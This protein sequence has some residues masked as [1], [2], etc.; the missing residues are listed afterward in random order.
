MTKRFTS[1]AR[2]SVN[3]IRLF[4]GFALL[5]S[6]LVLPVGVAEAAETVE[7]EAPGKMFPESRNVRTPLTHPNGNSLHSKIKT[8]GVACKT[9]DGVAALYQV[10]DDKIETY[11]PKTGTYTNSKPIN[12]VDDN[13]NGLLVDPHG[14]VFAAH[15]VKDT[16]PKDNTKFNHEFVQ[17]F[18]EDGTFTV[19]IEELPLEKK[20]WNAGTYVE[21]G[22]VPYA[23]ISN[24]FANNTPQLINLNTLKFD[25]AKFGVSQKNV[26][27]YVWVEEGIKVGTNKNDPTYHLVGIWVKNKSLKVYLSD[28]NGNGETVSSILDS[29]DFDGTYGAAYNFKNGSGD[30]ITTS[31][32]FSNNDKGEMT[33]LLFDAETKKFTLKAVGGSED[34]KNNDGGGCPFTEAGEEWGSVNVLNVD[35]DIQTDAKG[36]EYVGDETYFQIEITNNS[37]KSEEFEIYATV[38][39]DPDDGNDPVETT[40]KDSAKW[41]WKKVPVSA[42]SK[43]TFYGKVNWGENWAVK[44][45]DADTKVE[46][47]FTPNGSDKYLVLD[48]DACKGRKPKE[49]NFEPDATSFT[50]ACSEETPKIPQVTV[51]L[52]NSDSTVDATFTFVVEGGTDPEPIRVEAEEDYTITIN[53]DQDTEW[54]I[55]WTAKPPED[56]GLNSVEGK[57]EP[58]TKN[59]PTDCKDD[60]KFDPTF[61]VEIVCNDEKIPEL[62]FVF[63]NSKS[64]VGG[65]LEVWLY[66]DEAPFDGEG[67]NWPAV[68]YFSAGDEDPW[69]PVPLP[70]DSTWYFDWKLTPPEDSVFDP[71]ESTE[72]QGVKS[73]YHFETNLSD[74]NCV[75]I[76]ECLQLC[77]DVYGYV[78]VDSNKDGERTEIDGGDEDHVKGVEVVLSNVSAILNADG[79][80]NIPKGEYKREAVTGVDP[81]SGTDESNYRWYIADVHVEDFSGT[82]NKIEWQVTFDY[83]NAEWPEGFE[84]AGY[85]EKI[86]DEPEGKVISSEMDSDV[87]PQGGSIGVSGSFF[88]NVDEE[89]HRA[90]A[91]VI[92]GDPKVFEPEITVTLQCT[93]NGFNNPSVDLTIIVDNSKSEVEAIV[94]V[95]DGDNL[96]V[97]NP[98]DVPAGDDRA[99]LLTSI[100]EHGEVFEVRVVAAENEGLYEPI[101]ESVTIDCPRFDVEVEL[102]EIDCKTK[103]ATVIFKNNSDVSVS[104]DYT[105]SMTMI[106]GGKTKPPQKDSGS[107]PSL[108]PGEQEA[109]QIAVD[110]NWTW[111]L[112][113]TVEDDDIFSDHEWSDRGKLETVPAT[114]FVPCPG[115]SEFE[116]EV[117]ISVECT[118]EGPE[119]TYKVDNRSSDVDVE[120]ALWNSD[121]EGPDYT[122][123]VKAGEFPGTVSFP[124][125]A[126]DLIWYL[127]VR[128]AGGIL[129]G[130]PAVLVEV[131]VECHVP[132]LYL[133]QNCATMELEIVVNNSKPNYPTTLT[134]IET[135]PG[136]SSEEVLEIEIAANREFRRY[137]SLPVSDVEGVIYSAT[138]TGGVGSSYEPVTDEMAITCEWPID[139]KPF[140]CANNPSLLQLIRV[141]EEEGFVVKSLDLSDGTY[142]RLYEMPYDLTDPKF[143]NFNAVAIDPT[144]D[145]AYGVVSHELDSGR[146][147]FL[148]RFGMSN[149]DSEQKIAY[150]AEILGNSNSATIDDDGDFLFL[151]SGSLYLVDKV[152]DLKGF[153]SYDN[154]GVLDLTADQPIY[155]GPFE[156]HATDI[157]YA[158]FINGASVTKS[159]FG[160]TTSGHKV[161]RINYE[162]GTTEGTLLNPVDQNGVAVTFPPGGFG[163]AWNT[164]GRIIL[165]FN[166]GG[167][168]EIYPETITGSQVQVRKIFDT[169]GTGWNDGMNCANIPVC[170]PEE[171]GNVYG[172]A[173]ADWEK[174]GDRTPGEEHLKGVTVTLTLE[175]EYKNS[176]GDV[177]EDYGDSSWVVQTDGESTTDYE[178]R[179]NDV[180][181][182]DNDGNDLKYKTTFDYSTVLSF[183]TG[184]SPYGYTKRLEDEVTDSEIDSDVTEI[185]I[186]TSTQNVDQSLLRIKETD[187]MIFRLLMQHKKTKQKNISR[188]FGMATPLSED[189]EPQVTTAVSDLFTLE[190]NQTVHRADAGIV[191][192]FYFE[193]VVE[194]TIDCAEESAI[195]SLDNSGSSVSTTF[196]VDVYHGSEGS[197]N[198]VVDQSGEQLVAAGDT[199]QYEKA[200]PP[201]LGVLKVKVTAYAEHNGILLGPELVASNDSGTYCDPPFSVTLDALVKCP[202]LEIKI[203]NYSAEQLNLDPLPAA[204]PARIEVTLYVDGIPQR[205]GNIFSE[206]DQYYELD[207]GFLIFEEIPLEEGSVW[208]LEYKITDLTYPE[209]TIEGT[210]IGPEPFDCI[211]E[212]PPDPEVTF[213][214]DCATGR[215]VFTIDNSKSLWNIDFTI[216]KLGEIIRGPETVNAKV[217]KEI[218]LF[219][220]HD[221]DYIVLLTLSEVQPD[222]ATFSQVTV[223]EATQ[224]ASQIT[225]QT[226]NAGSQD[227][228]SVVEVVIESGDTLS[229][230]AAEHGIKTSELMAANGIEDASRIYIGQKLT[231][232]K[233]QQEPDWEAI[234]QLVETLE[235]DKNSV[236][237]AEG[238][239]TTVEVE[240]AGEGFPFK[241]DCPVFEPEIDFNEFCAD[242][243]LHILV[244]NE[245]SDIAGE[246]LIYENGELVSEGAVLPG[247]EFK[248]EY[249]FTYGA[250]YKVVV[251]PVGSSNGFSYDPVDGEHEIGCE[252]P[253][254]PSLEASFECADY[255]PLATVKLNNKDSDS[256]TEFMLTLVIDGNP[257]RIEIGPINVNAGSEE[258]ID[259]TDEF[260]VPRSAL[261][262]GTWRFEWTATDTE[263]ENREKTGSTPGGNRNDGSSGGS[264]CIDP[265]GPF[266]CA[267]YLAPLQIVLADSGIGY[268]LNTLNLAT[269]FLEDIYTIPFN[270]TIPSYSEIN[271][272]GLNPDPSDQTIYGF[273]RIKEDNVSSSY[274]IRFD[275]QQ[276]EY[277]AQVTNFPNAATF[278]DQGNFL[279]MTEGSLYKAENAKDIKGYVDHKD[280]RVPDLR[281]DPPVYDARDEGDVYAHAVDIAHV[282]TD[283]GLGETDY[284]VGMV[285]GADQVVLIGYDGADLD[286]RLLDS[287][288]S[289]G[290]TDEL[291]GG[292]YGSAWSIGGQVFVAA[293]SGEVFQIALDGTEVNPFPFNGSVEIR[294]VG[295]SAVSAHNDGTNCPGVPICFPEIFGDAYGYVWIDWD[296]SKDRTDIEYGREEHIAGVN[297]ILENTSPFYDSEGE[298][299]YQPGELKV[300]STITGQGSSAGNESGNYRWWIDDLPA[301]DNSG[302]RIKYEAIFDYAGGQ[303]PQGFTPTGYTGKQRDDVLSSEK[304]SD[305][306]PQ[307]FTRSLNTQAVSGEFTIEPETST[308]TADAGVIGEPKF[309]PTATV[310]IDCDADTADIS[311]DNSESTVQAKYEI[312]VYHGDVD[313]NNLVQ[314]Q[315]GDKIVEAYKTVEYGKY[316]PP[317]RGQ[318]LTILITATPQKEDLDLGFEPVTVWNQAG[319]DCPTGFVVQVQVETDCDSGGIKVTLDNSES[320]VDARF[321]LVLGTDTET[322]IESK[323][324]TQ[325]E[326]EEVIISVTE[327]SEWTLIWKAVETGESEEEKGFVG[328]IGPEQF[329]CEPEEFLPIVSVDHVC[330]ILGNTATFSIDNTGSGVNAIVEVYSDDELIWGPTTIEKGT[331]SYETT[332]PVTGIEAITIRVAAEE[333][334]HNYGTTTIKET[335]NCPETQ[336]APFD[337]AAFPALIQIVGTKGVGFEVKELNPAS[338]EYRPIYS[339]PFNRTPAFSGMNGAGINKVDSTAYALM[340]LNPTSPYLVRFDAQEVLFVAK[341]PEFSAAGDV[342]EDGN[343]VWPKNTKRTLSVLP[344]IA[345]LEGFTNPDDAADMSGLSPTLEGVD[346]PVSDIATMIYDFGDG[347]G[348]YAMGLLGNDLYVYRYDDPNDY[349][350][351]KVMLPEG[352]TSPAPKGDF[353][354]AWSHED[355]I[356][357]ASNSGLGV[358]EVMIPTIDF[359]N[360]TAEIR[361]V[362]NS[363]AT[364]WND[365]MNCTGIPTC[366]PDIFGSTY[367]YSWVD[368]ETSGDR[369]GIEDGTEEHIAGVKVTLTNTTTYYDSEGN[370]CYGPG[371]FTLETTTGADDGLSGQ[372]NGDYRWYFSDVPVEDS[373]GNEMRYEIFFDYEEATFPEGFTPLGYT[374]QLNDGLEDSEIDSDARPIQTTFS[375]TTKAVTPRRVLGSVLAKT[376]PQSPHGEPLIKILLPFIIQ[377]SPSRLVVVWIALAGSEPPLG[378]V[379]ANQ[380][381]LVLSTV[382]TPYFWLK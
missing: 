57:Y 243:S 264:S 300:S 103:K 2:K 59:S 337:C 310:E 316:I 170:L 372:D 381:F 284:V 311:L 137:W 185:T 32:F 118:D 205:L 81:N 341:M 45:R 376:I 61:T 33:Q 192:T 132:E 290:S 186:E 23:L 270:R 246:V 190:P 125:K 371:E 283:I 309:D 53:L 18:P 202:V 377:S 347:E 313:E 278:D 301:E 130:V 218:E 135:L 296:A 153:S 37:D 332:I 122:G 258:E 156:Y 15:M 140:D 77:G 344:D 219:V 303:F 364:S 350:K 105:T 328:F 363:D 8:G 24:G 4:I 274:M 26:K 304:D 44:V 181:A 287:V 251:N 356:Y 295:S 225:K 108:G 335:L 104:F 244:S 116:P 331:E 166:P 124:G 250:I 150:L 147:D 206:S 249:P 41:K 17:V 58:L 159:I 155:K 114:S 178:W 317:P 232:S 113:W 375:S 285:Y 307:N 215:G 265:V 357:F 362:A 180:P 100:G 208:V 56:S 220:E 323:E 121:D 101:V 297:V 85:T 54:S 339:I 378:S 312:S 152:G 128:P 71:K 40:N 47:P 374:Q 352:S 324:V 64:S 233:T 160:I 327:D 25:K 43:D 72:K 151:F 68:D 342:D 163:A 273:I 212:P 227:L 52:N 22:N 369:T 210:V 197:E 73:P 191:G 95:T 358:F 51:N 293:I 96:A 308:H 139:I 305:V 349:W 281:N 94:K 334:S 1:Q 36:N 66:V 263:N 154:P 279:W 266:D 260:G 234:S 314:S 322:G 320:S 196:A 321:S 336:V 138:L 145:K 12:D 267:S 67:F 14:R 134:L 65:K 110:K 209:R 131:T 198:K 27:D 148:V 201:P 16:S 102:G 3:M 217:T 351:I 188:V 276:I 241:V 240:Y 82:G 238:E 289:K 268:E 83:E 315:S 87:D 360:K 7:A 252:E 199:A 299:C 143:T 55:S 211:V 30:D 168:Y 10:L 319:V 253:F 318:I 245:D 141:S 368:W 242:E 164:D 117:K 91:G 277:L 174:S 63:D 302:N 255:G 214:P 6:T 98:S 69:R 112:N 146:R 247:R 115:G 173:W 34:T 291:P 90:D 29:N 92:A 97:G 107:G 354:A 207:D 39:D 257:E 359:E 86:N 189:D 231:I 340:S 50:Y 379:I 158:E 70:E 13:L 187:P 286:R 361:K 282:R 298:P 261:E 144:D 38:D 275:S 222:A 226:L 346:A 345:S 223:K 120:F 271:G 89:E 165:G 9:A 329:D 111:L 373:F 129:E 179:I 167:I 230:I 184:F 142:K 126:N 175:S 216:K 161:L 194:V 177:C 259:I 382:G 88:L 28:I 348:S 172:Y 294:K 127:S 367:G 62:V 78:W 11:E 254:E 74:T 292:G 99:T 79:T 176:E 380:P 338:G 228:V 272:I 75:E 353:G 256:T 343:F 119:V 136:G 171:F 237:F 236:L 123:E 280:L 370:E 169:E 235:K 133:L 19:L 288:D 80:V 35:C 203:R 213:V 204:G 20:A 333:N 325:G 224:E 106:G 183:P 149:I 21:I 229:E 109:Q 262:D 326:K 42:K 365:G 269:G 193:P 366:I 248:V 46:I 60:P 5:A 48:E 31:M 239:N 76:P 157:T 84:P 49:D 182:K 355:R 195:V 330:D 162:E 200:I 93:Y 306:S 221:D